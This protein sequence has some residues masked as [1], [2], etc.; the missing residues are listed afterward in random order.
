MPPTIDAD[1]DAVSLEELEQAVRSAP[2]RIAVAK[3]AEMDALRCM[4]AP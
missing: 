4:G 2:P 3:R 1:G